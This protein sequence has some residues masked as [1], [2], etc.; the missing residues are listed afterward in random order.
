MKD[1]FMAEIRKRE[2]MKK[3][4]SKYI[5]VFDY[6][7]NI[8]LALSATSGGVTIA[9]FATVIG[10]TVEIT[11]KSLSLIFS[12]SNR[13]AKKPLKTTRKKKHN[14]VVLLAKS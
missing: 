14:K 3:T 12:I 11:I 10:A 2:T 8:L 1:H 4:L 9:S 5:A 6:L 13:I 7:D